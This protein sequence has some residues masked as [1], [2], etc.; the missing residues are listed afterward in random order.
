LL[1]DQINKLNEYHQIKSKNSNEFKS[2]GKFKNK[3]IYRGMNGGHFYKKNDCEKKYIN[4][5]MIE[6]DKTSMESID[7]FLFFSNFSNVSYLN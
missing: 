6:F 2:I 4:P 5:E 7:S 1:L 3:S